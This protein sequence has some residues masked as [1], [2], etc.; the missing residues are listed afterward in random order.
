MH[1]GLGW[2]TVAMQSDNVYTFSLLLLLTLQQYVFLALSSIP[3]STEAEKKIMA[4][5]DLSLI[6]FYC[7]LF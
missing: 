6:C 5:S 3:L 2:S 1:R 4:F 7:Y